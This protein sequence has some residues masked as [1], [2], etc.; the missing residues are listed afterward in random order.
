[1][2]ARFKSWIK[3]T[4]TLMRYPLVAHNSRNVARLF[5]GESFFT[6][7]EAIIIGGLAAGGKTLFA[8]T[9]L[10]AIHF[11]TEIKWFHLNKNKRV[12]LFFSTEEDTTELLAKVPMETKLA[13]SEIIIKKLSTETISNVCSHIKRIVAETANEPN[14]YL[15]C[16]VIDNS[17]LLKQSSDNNFYKAL[18]KL[19]QQYNF[20]VIFTQAIKP[21][22]HGR[23]SLDRRWLEMGNIELIHSRSVNEV[24]KVMYI[25]VCHSGD[26]MF[27]KKGKH[28]GALRSPDINVQEISMRN[29]TV[30]LSI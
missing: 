1:M 24:D 23:K 11:A 17:H 18:R 13:D 28:N 15:Q 29:K 25:D 21:H 19:A 30:A 10:K 8:L 5:D 6:P 7:G 3:E 12:S 27:I 2:F 26:R 20:V 4:I 22:F 9:L 14:L 16:V